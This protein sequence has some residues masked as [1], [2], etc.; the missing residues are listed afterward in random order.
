MQDVAFSMGCNID[1]QI[2]HSKVMWRMVTEPF[3]EV[4]QEIVVSS[5]MYL[6]NDIHIIMIDILDGVCVSKYCSLTLNPHNKDFCSICLS[7]P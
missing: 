5:E 2:T 3:V 7:L 6:I 1:L 4:V